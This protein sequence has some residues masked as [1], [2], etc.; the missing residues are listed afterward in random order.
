MQSHAQSTFRW[1]T[2]LLIFVIS[3]IAAAC[4]SDAQES[5]LPEG[6]DG[7][8]WGSSILVE[9]RDGQSVAIIQG[10][11]PDSCST[12][13]GNEQTVS[14]NEININ[15]YSS[16]PE[17]MVCAEVLTPFEE[18][19]LLDTSGLEPGEYTITLNED[20]AQTTFTLE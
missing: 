2:V 18:E 3:L 10:D 15:L 6:C 19:I 13:C 8:T 4:S 12:V 11:Y 16:R 7:V 5:T 9:E 14:G 1:R 17:D 20:H